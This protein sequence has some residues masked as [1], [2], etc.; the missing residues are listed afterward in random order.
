M[1]MKKHTKKVSQEKH[2]RIPRMRGFT[3]EHLLKTLDRVHAQAEHDPI[4]RK[5]MEDIGRLSYGDDFLS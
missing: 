4:L 1:Y 3:M 5:F 2:E